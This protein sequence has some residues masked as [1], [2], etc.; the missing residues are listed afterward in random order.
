MKSPFYGDS[1]VEIPGWST[2]WNPFASAFFGSPENPG[3]VISS[4]TG[5]KILETDQPAAGP[6][7]VVNQVA[8][9]LGVDPKAAQP[10]TEDFYR[11]VKVGVFY[12]SN[13]SIIQSQTSQAINSSM[14]NM[15]L[16]DTLRTRPFPGYVKSVAGAG[17]GATTALTIAIADIAPTAEI[18][19]PWVFVTIA[20]SSLT[21]KAGGLMSF[22][23]GGKTAN[24]VVVADTP[25]SIKRENI[26]KAVRI[27][28]FPYVMMAARPLHQTVAVG[29]FG[30]VAQ[31]LT[32]SIT[33][34]AAD[35]S[36]TIEIPGYSMGSLREISMKFGFPAGLSF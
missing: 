20:A 18:G 14:I 8:R 10:S 5:A 15:A 7:L 22:S 9:D 33:G 32:V 29:T 3:V 6:A 24:G 21:A 2:P 11:L 19:I 30:G 16:S 23:L 35:E 12:A 36:V 28:M 25:W 31:A 13:A 4:Q 26:A 34:V 27:I 1:T 17:L